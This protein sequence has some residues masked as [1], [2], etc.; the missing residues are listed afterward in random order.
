MSQDQRP[1]DHAQEHFSSI[2]ED[3]VMIQIKAIPST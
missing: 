2:F 3:Q 1:V